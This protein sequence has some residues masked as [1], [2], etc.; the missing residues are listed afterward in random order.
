M[1]RIANLVHYYRCTRFRN[2][3]II[4]RKE[5]LGK[6][7]QGTFV[8]FGDNKPLK[9]SNETEAGL[10]LSRHCLQKVVAC[11]AHCGVHMIDSYGHVNNAKY[12]ELFEYGRWYANAF[13]GWGDYLASRQIHSHVHNFSIQYIREIKPFADTKVSQQITTM[14]PH[15][16]E[17]RAT[18]LNSVQGI[19][20]GDGSKIH[21]SAIVQLGFVG[22]ASTE[23]ELVSQFGDE[24]EKRVYATRSAAPQQLVALDAIRVLAAASKIPVDEVHT[25]LL[26]SRESVTAAASVKGKKPQSSDGDTKDWLEHLNHANGQWL[27]ISK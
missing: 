12:L 13:A 3:G 6:I 4:D 5:A 8:P 23:H 10:L 19:W 14:Y 22:P 15:G 1:P 11:N 16:R 7:L 24:E 27:N 18:C 21:S 17:K 26:S 9:A 2:K 25:L 20:N